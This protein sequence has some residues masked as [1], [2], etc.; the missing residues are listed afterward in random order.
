M[1]LKTILDFPHEAIIETRPA[2]ADVI[3][4]IAKAEKSGYPLRKPPKR[5]M[6]RSLRIRSGWLALPSPL[7]LCAQ[8]YRAN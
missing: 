8:W 3:F 5:S 4:E 2:C 6:L 7:A 1:K